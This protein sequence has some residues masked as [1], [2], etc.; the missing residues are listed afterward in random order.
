MRADQHVI[1]LSVDLTAKDVLRMMGCR[2]PESIRDEV[3]AAVERLTDEMR[4]TV[5]PRGTYV[6]Y[7]VE[8]MTENLLKMQSCPAIHGPIA[9]FLRPARRVAAFIV[10][11]GGDMEHLSAE[12][13]G[14]GEMLE[15]YTLNAIGSAAADLASDAIADHIFWNHAGPE[16][17]ITP[18][19]SPGYCGMA[20]EEQSTIFTIV[21]GSTIGVKLWP[22]MIMEPVKS[23]SG[24]LG[25]GDRDK[26]AT[27]GVP[28][29]WC[30]LEKCQMRRG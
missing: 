15:G 19:F 28:C 27:H 16:E 29:Q 5:R 4:D 18:P 2:K 12:R 17:G 10:T 23:V 13:I 22:T 30:E 25:I 24:L 21:D 11:I 1:D 14:R 9:T 8:E 7:D 20:L 26:V 6:I 3:R